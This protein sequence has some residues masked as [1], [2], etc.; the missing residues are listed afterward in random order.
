MVLDART[1]LYNDEA[2]WYD[3]YVSAFVSQDPAQADINL[4]RYCGNSPQT[5]TDPFGLWKVNRARGL[6]AQATRQCGDTLATLGQYIGL[7]PKDWHNW[8]TIPLSSHTVR[9][10]DGNWMCA[11]DLRADSKL[12]NGFTFE[13]PNVMMCLWYGDVG[14]TGKGVSY[15][16]GVND[17]RKL[18]FN[19]DLFNDCHKSAVLSVLAARSTAKTL[20]G[21]FVVGH[22]LPTSFGT[23]NGK[24]DWNNTQE[25]IKYSEV[26]DQIKNQ[27]LL[28]A[29]ILWVCYGKFSQPN[30]PGSI[31]GR[32]IVSASPSAVFDG[33][34]RT[35]VPFVDY[36][37]MYKLFRDGKQGTIV[38]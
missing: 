23:G 5:S 30:G 24:W 29:A 19:T 8:L 36:T 35:L 10:M 11:E 22:G 16:V 14:D 25:S 28:G 37:L 20:H 31:G 9:M 17:L 1:G 27:Y 26:Y 13:I 33:V 38:P 34:S 15:D 32:D 2:R 7:D 6:T 18:G 12:S 21:L 3:G 4:Y